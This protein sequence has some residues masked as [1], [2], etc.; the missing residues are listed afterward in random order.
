MR[1]KFEQEAQ[2]DL[3]YFY[4]HDKKK[5]ERIFQLLEDIQ[6]SPFSGIGKPEKLKYSLEG[7][8]SR[9]IDREHRLVYQVDSKEIRI[10]ACRYHYDR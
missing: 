1:I 4:R 3:D 2:Q 8:W 6:N 10:L 9:R 5:V 7:C